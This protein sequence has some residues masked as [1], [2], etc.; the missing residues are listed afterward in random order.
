MRVQLRKKRKFE[1]G[2]QAANTRIGARSIKIIRTRGGNKKYRA[3]RLD[4]GNFTWG[5]ESISRPTRIIKVVYHPSNNE[6][7]RTN[8]LTK[9]AIVQIDAHPF[10]SYFEGHYGVPASS[11]GK[12]T[13]E[14]K[15]TDETRARAAEAKLSAG[16]EP[17][18]GSGRIYACIS[19]R[20]GQTG[21]V[22]GYILEGEELQFY[23]EKLASH[24]K[25]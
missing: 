3:L 23:L 12:V 14:L 11:R 9:N 16:L 20:P 24:K 17:Q 4:H 21:R 10:R 6:L 5:T 22:D 8:T 19:S 1:S 15:E 2:R 18:F 13:D 25:K 7:M